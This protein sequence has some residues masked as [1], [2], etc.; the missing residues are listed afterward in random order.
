M[1]Y[2]SLIWNTYRHEKKTISSETMTLSSQ[3]TICDTVTWGAH[4]WDSGHDYI[5]PGAKFLNKHQRTFYSVHVS[6]HCSIKKLMKSA[7]LRS[8]E[9]YTQVSPNGHVMHDKKMPPTNQN[10]RQWH[11][12]PVS[13]KRALNEEIPFS[14]R[15]FS[16]THHSLITLNWHT[17]K[18]LTK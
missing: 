9:N 17:C 11:F 10:I 1:S 13:T 16:D 2:T 7:K 6:I 12:Q 8:L 18:A 5:T 15:M 4:T 14:M 3:P